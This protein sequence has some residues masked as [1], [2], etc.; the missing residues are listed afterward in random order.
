MDPLFGKRDFG[1]LAYPTN[2]IY[3]RL[4][5]NYIFSPNP[6]SKVNLGYW[7]CYLRCRSIAEF[8]ACLVFFGLLF[9]SR[10]VKNLKRPL[11]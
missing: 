4:Q 6:F 5:N 3:L 9:S 11:R 8:K 1:K 10:Q 2:S 7:I